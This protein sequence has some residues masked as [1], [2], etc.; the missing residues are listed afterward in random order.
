MGLSVQSSSGTLEVVS[1]SSDNILSRASPRNSQPGCRP[2]FAHFQLSY[3]V[4]DKSTSP[5]RS[6]IITTSRKPINKPVCFSSEQTV[7]NLLQ[8]ETRSTRMEDRCLQF[9]MDTET[10]ASMLSHHFLWWEKF[11]Q[12]SCQTSLRTYFL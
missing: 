1:A 10:K 8:L 7:S 9:A 11:W 4:V 6:I 2:S 5:E 3:R 12:K